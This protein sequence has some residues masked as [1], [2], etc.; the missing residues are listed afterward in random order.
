MKGGRPKRPALEARLVREALADA[1]PAAPREPLAR[2]LARRVVAELAKFVVDDDPLALAL[3]DLRLR[4]FPTPAR[5]LAT[6]PELDTL[7]LFVER[8]VA[9]VRD[10]AGRYL[11]QEAARTEREQILS[12]LEVA[13][14]RRYLR[15]LRAARRL[16]NVG[17]A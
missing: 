15:H 3:A 10:R 16:G 12:E 14:S 2:D 17:S 11:G 9:G 6:D 13:L 8:R 4:A 7:G 1:D 5:S